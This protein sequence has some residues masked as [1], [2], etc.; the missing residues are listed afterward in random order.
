MSTSKALTRRNFLRLAGLGSAGAAIAACAAP[1]APGAP[2]TP[3]V[4]EKVVEQVSTVLVEKAVEVEKIVTVEVPQEGVAA[5]AQVTVDGTL[6]IIQKRDFFPEFNDWWRAQVLDFCRKGWPVD[7]LQ[8]GFTSGTPWIEKLTAQA[9]P[10]T[11]PT[12]SCTDSAVQMVN[13]NPHRCRTSWKSSRPA[14]KQRR[15]NTDFIFE[16]SGASCAPALRRRL[17]PV[18]GL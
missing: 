14:A 8:A 12:W 1:A 4:V 10:A 17:V 16:V 15:F 13:N 11:L 7:D 18:A 2:A 9:A 3:I 5:P 6:W